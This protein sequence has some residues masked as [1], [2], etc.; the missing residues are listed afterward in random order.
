LAFLFVILK[1]IS[2]GFFEAMGNDFYR[3]FSIESLKNSI[4]PSLDIIGDLCA[5]GAIVL[6]GTG[7]W[8]YYKTDKEKKNK[9]YPIRLTKKDETRIIDKIKHEQ[10]KKE[11]QELGNDEDS[12]NGK[13]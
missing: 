11:I 9:K 2:I 10:R 12:E 13:R 7:L 4:V 1:S 3:H 8:K 6:I 5:V